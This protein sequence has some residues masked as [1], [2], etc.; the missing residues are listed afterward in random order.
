MSTIPLPF[1]PLSLEEV[2]AR[3]KALFEELFP[4]VLENES[5]YYMPVIEDFAEKE[6]RLRAEANANWKQNWWQTAT[7]EGLDWCAEFFGVTRLEGTKPWARVSVS[8]SEAKSYPVTLPAGILLGDENGHS[9]R[10][11]EAV[12]IPAGEITVETT[13]VLDLYTAS[14]DIKTETVLT[15]LPWL[16][17]VKQLEAYHSGREQES[18]DD[19]RERIRLS[20]DT[21]SG[22]GP[23]KAYI[24]HTLDA[25]SRIRD[26]SVYE[27]DSRVQIV[28]DS[29]EWDDELVRR[30]EEHTTADDVRPLTDKVEI[31]RAVVDPYDIRA[32]LTI[33]EGYDAAEVIVS[34]RENALRRLGNTKIEE[35]VSLAKIIDALFVD[36]VE[37][38]SLLDPGSSLSPERDHVARLRNVELSYDA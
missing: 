25:D 32:T 3:N 35:P 38:L 26:V 18:D 23:T 17:I 28:V 14:S 15:T 20:L 4:G 1:E 12:I 9:A 29:D 6:I 22:A 19:L 16:V 11:T 30:I 34:A 10:I 36:G 24:K 31:R 2:V 37:D 8:I 27:I 7:G 5:D 13:A 33:A 21:L